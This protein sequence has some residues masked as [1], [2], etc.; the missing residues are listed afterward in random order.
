MNAESCNTVAV[1]VS[2][3][4]QPHFDSTLSLKSN[5]GPTKRILNYN[6]AKEPMRE[7]SSCSKYPSNNTL[8]QLHAGLHAGVTKLCLHTTQRGLSAMFCSVM[9]QS[10]SDANEQE[11]R[12]H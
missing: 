5:A 9:P 10:N 12:S 6:N 3:G 4:N 7:L 8:P 11:T 1:F 2:C